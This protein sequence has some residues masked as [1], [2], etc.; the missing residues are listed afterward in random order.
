MNLQGSNIFSSTG[1]D[2]EENAREIEK[3]DEELRELE[4]KLGVKSDPKKKDRLQKSI[5]S[6]G[7]GKGFL[8]FLDDIG[9]KVKNKS[10]KTM[11]RDEYAKK[12]D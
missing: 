4:K 11:K 8:S 3:L 12:V 1:V 5:E 2:Q 7:L 6:E 10:L 9:S